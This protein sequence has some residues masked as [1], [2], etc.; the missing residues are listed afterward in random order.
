MC[1]PS[2]GISHRGFHRHC[3]EHEA[4]AV[5]LFVPPACM[6]R[7]RRAVGSRRAAVR[8]ND[9]RVGLGGHS[10]VDGGALARGRRVTPKPHVLN[11]QA[12]VHV[13]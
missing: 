9:S 12:H 10:R 8:H 4:R 7:L 1:I 2:R 6:R 13:W 5:D 3:V 11:L